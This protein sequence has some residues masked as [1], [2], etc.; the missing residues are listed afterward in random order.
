MTDEIAYQ[1]LTITIKDTMTDKVTT[2]T[3]RVKG[4]EIVMTTI[5]PDPD[6]TVSPVP[7]TFIPTREIVKVHLTGEWVQHHDMHY[8]I[9]ILDELFGIPDDIR[10]SGTDAVPDGRDTSG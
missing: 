9:T 5:R 7:V 10:G 1:E 6:L 3:G 4:L 2:L 8:M